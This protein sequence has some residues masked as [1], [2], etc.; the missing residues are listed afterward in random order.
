[1]LRGGGVYI[2][3]KEYDWKLKFSVQT[4][5]THINNVFESCYSSVNLDDLHLHLE[6]G[7]YIGYSEK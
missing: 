7:N 6:D 1:M 5:L 3:G 4:Y 2:S